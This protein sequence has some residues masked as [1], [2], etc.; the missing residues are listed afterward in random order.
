MSYSNL[1]LDTSN[2]VAKLTLNRPERLNA[3]SS[4]LL[5]ELIQAAEQVS[6]SDAR[7]LVICGAGRSFCAGVD[8]DTFMELIQDSRV[9]QRHAAFKLGGAMGDAIESI[10]QVVVVALHGHV[11][12]G[13]LVL[14]AACDLRVA[15]DD[16]MFSIPEID[17]GVPLGW[18]GID[19]LTR[20]IGPTRTKEFVMTGRTFTAQEAFAAGFLNTTVESDKVQSAAL[21]LAT[22]IASKPRL[23]IEITKRHIA[24]ILKGDRSR[25]DNLTAVLDFDHP[26]SVA[27]RLPY[28]ARFVDPK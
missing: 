6:E 9:E 3:L 20:E 21:D 28:V 15:A 25:D 14:A 11:V 27:M 24:E 22:T 26:D 23:P 2:D 8:I 10:P 4:D 5:E 19:R 16:T 12:G 18:G 1:I 17:L 13:G 7:A